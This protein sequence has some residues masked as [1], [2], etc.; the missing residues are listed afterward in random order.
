VAL[1]TR[2][3]RAGDELVPVLLQEPEMLMPSGL[4][5]AG[6]RAWSDGRALVAVDPALALRAV[7]RCGPWRP[8]DRLW[9]VS[10]A[11]VPPEVAEAVEGRGAAI[12]R[13]ALV[14]DPDGAERRVSVAIRQAGRR[15]E[16]R[17]PPI[18]PHAGAILLRD[19]LR[20]REVAR[21]PGDPWFD[22]LLWA[23]SGRRVMAH[24]RNGQWVAVAVPRKGTH[25]VLKTSTVPV[26]PVPLVALGWARGHAVAIGYGDGHWV[27]SGL[28]H[29]IAPG[30]APPP[31]MG[32]VVSQ[33]GPLGTWIAIGG[34]LFR[35]VEEASGPQVVSL[36][37]GHL[38]LDENTMW[39][40]RREG[41]TLQQTVVGAN[42]L[43]EEA[44]RVVG[45]P[46][47]GA[48]LGDGSVVV[49]HDRT[50]TS[51]PWT[52]VL[53][54]GHDL[55]GVLGPE[56]RRGVVTVDGS[57]RLQLVVPPDGLPQD[58]GTA[59]GPVAFGPQGCVA[60]MEGRELHVQE[61]GAPRPVLRV[62]AP[63][64]VP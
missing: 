64:R 41:D 62:R 60:W 54:E 24:A 42:G 39:V 55:V 31:G 52:Y 28:S 43:E 50:L 8:S 32:V 18:D 46:G 20:R 59:T 15:A 26:P 11:P 37:R 16:V 48:T 61:L 57:R 21:T 5:R 25:Q 30:P 47:S 56:G 10:P 9:W 63:G 34:E 29:A 3:A 53:P 1:A 19:P 2:A 27:R 38:R 7:Q 33:R 36:G 12:A 14:D 13:V 58:L 22:A 6:V 51:G 35:W 4:A 49:L 45:V 40:L 23:P 17:L 44:R